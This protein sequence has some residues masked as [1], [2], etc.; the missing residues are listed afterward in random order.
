[1][2]QGIRI[3]FCLGNT[4]LALFGVVTRGLLLDPNHDSLDVVSRVTTGSLSSLFYIKCPFNPQPVE[5]RV[6][7]LLSFY[8]NPVIG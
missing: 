6:H 2:L 1:M 3:Q 5:P 4:K 7:L 8:S